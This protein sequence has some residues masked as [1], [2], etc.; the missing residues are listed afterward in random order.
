[1]RRKFAKATAVAA[2]TVAG[3]GAALILLVILAAVD[4]ILGNRFLT[5][6][7]GAFVVLSIVVGATTYR[8]VRTRLARRKA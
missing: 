3:V 5:L 8:A 2:G 1:V 4:T 7:A 6:I